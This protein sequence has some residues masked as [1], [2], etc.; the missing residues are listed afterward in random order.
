MKFLT[1]VLI[2]IPISMAVYWFGYRSGRREGK[3]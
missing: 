1:A 3:P 2:Q